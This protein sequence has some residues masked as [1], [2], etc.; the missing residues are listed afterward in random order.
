[1]T[2]EIPLTQG[3]VAIVDDDVYESISRHCWQALWDG[4]CFYAARRVA[5]RKGERRVVMM[6]REIVNAPDN[7]NVDH[8]N[9]NGLDN[10]R[11]NLR[12]CT[13]AQNTHNRRKNKQSMS[14]YKGVC[15]MGKI[16]KWMA[17][18]MVDGESIY[19]GVFS[20]QIDAARAYDNAAR[21]HY[22][23]FA[24]LNFPEDPDA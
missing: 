16:G 23:E 4:N 15:W 18:I 9:G 24:W 20:E 2:K 8:K 1:M 13:Q 17:R 5:T 7:L 10:R 12:I 19:L 6:H 11:A 22:G 21:I 3:Q 14:I